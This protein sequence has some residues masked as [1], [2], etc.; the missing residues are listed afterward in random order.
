[1]PVHDLATIAQA[2]KILGVSTKTLRRWENAGKIESIKTF[3]G[4]R[5]FRLEDINKIIHDYPEIKIPKQEIIHIIDGRK[6]SQPSFAFDLVLISFVALISTLMLIATN[7]AFFANPKVL[8][9]SKFLSYNENGVVEIQATQKEVTIEKSWESS[10]TS[11]FVT[12]SHNTQVW[13]TEVSEKGFVINVSNSPTTD[14]KLYW[15]AI[16]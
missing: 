5:R 2:A 10:P 9:I 6:Y 13:V 11:I 14:Q 15:W 4:H 7:P 16:W 8:G 3:G 1:M 12:A